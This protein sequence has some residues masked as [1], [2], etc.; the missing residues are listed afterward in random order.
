MGGQDWNKF[1]PPPIQIWSVLPGNTDDEDDDDDDISDD[2]DDDDNDDN[3]DDDDD[4]DDA[5]MRRF[6]CGCYCSKYSLSRCVL[7]TI[8]PKLQ[9]S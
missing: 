1:L 8:F 7:S 6:Y 2:D 3:N 4:D 5:G 9:S